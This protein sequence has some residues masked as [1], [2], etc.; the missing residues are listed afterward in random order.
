[1]TPFSSKQRVFHHKFVISRSIFG[2]Q[3]LSRWE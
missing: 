3:L 1:L 2:G